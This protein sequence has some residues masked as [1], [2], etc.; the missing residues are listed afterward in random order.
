M[1]AVRSRTGNQSARRRYQELKT[2]FR[3]AFTT[4]ANGLSEAY[5]TIALLM[6]ERSSFTE[7]RETGRLVSW[8]SRHVLETCAMVSRRTVNNYRSD[9]LKCGAIEC[10]HEGGRGPGDTPYF[11]FI[12]RWLLEVESS[13]SEKGILQ[14]WDRKNGGRSAAPL[15][16]NKGA[17]QSAPSDALANG[18]DDDLVIEVA[19]ALGE[20]REQASGSTLT[21]G[22]RVGQRR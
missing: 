9:M 2:R 13:L 19:D 21:F 3:F 22:A 6:V 11:A 8:V 7:F 5:R 20:T 15:D 4:P 10:L 17:I 16:R 14:A 12:E 1:G 18:Q